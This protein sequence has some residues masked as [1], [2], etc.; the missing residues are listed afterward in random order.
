MPKPFFW[1]MRVLF[2]PVWFSPD[3]VI[4]KKGQK[5][6]EI[7][8]WNQYNAIDLADCTL[9]TMM[10]GG[11]KWM[12]QMREYRDISVRC[13]PGQRTTATIPIWNKASAAALK[14]G[15]PFCCRCIVLDPDGFRPITKDI[16]VIPEEAAKARTAM[17]IGP[18]AV[19]G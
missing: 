19:L 15:S 1:A 12:G 10:G 4:W 17:P 16:L 8:V 5:Q 7:E 9:R 13:A 14:N 3:R 11:G 2:S 6:I 18:D